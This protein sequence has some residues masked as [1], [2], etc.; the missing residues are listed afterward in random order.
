MGDT[1]TSRGE[2]E[3]AVATFALGCFWGAEVGAV[4]VQAHKLDPGLKAPGFKISYLMK[5]KLAST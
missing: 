5:E 2:E 3:C 4:P 1:A